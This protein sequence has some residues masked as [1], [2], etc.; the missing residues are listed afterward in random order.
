MVSF[1]VSGRVIEAKDL[2]ESRE[3]IYSNICE[4]LKLVSLFVKYDGITISP[5]KIERKE[6]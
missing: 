3:P 2:E 5:L 4:V 1:A 6:E